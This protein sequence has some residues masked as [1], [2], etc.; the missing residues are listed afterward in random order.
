MPRFDILISG[1]TV[2]DGTGAPR[3]MADVG[4][5][6]DRIK[7]VEPHGSISAGD[8]AALRTIDARGLVVAPG[9]VDT[10]NHSDG[11]MLNGTH[12]VAK[13]TQGF[14][15][16]VLMSD[17][18]SYAPTS[19]RNARLWIA[20]LRSLDGL[21]VADYRG[22]ESIA[23]YLALIDRHNAQNCLAQIPYANIRVDAMGW[24]RGPADDT[25]IRLMQHA[26]RHAMDDGAA[27]VSTGLDYVAQCFAG[28]DEIAEVC[29]AMAL[30]G[31]LYVTHVRYK[32]GLVA[33]VKEAVEIGRRARV[34]VH[35]SHLK[36]STPEERD[37]LLEYIDRVAVHEVDF[38]FDVYPYL[39]GSTML[40]SL[41]PYDV[42]EAG[43]LAVTDRLLEPDVRR[44][45]AAQLDDYQLELDHIRLAWVA[46]KDNARYQGMSL[47][48]YSDT[49]RKS[50]VDA[51]CDLLVD[52]QLAV[53][54]VFF[55][56]DDSLV[57][58]FLT[59]PRFMIGSDGI[60]FPDTQ[61]HPRQFGSATRILGPLVRDRGL[62]TLEEAV[63][64]LS[65]FPSSRFGLTD[66][67][68]VQAGS[69]ADLVI[70]DP[71][72][73][74]DRATFENPQQTSIGIVE[75]LVNGVPVVSNGLPV[76]TWSGGPP[77]RALRFKGGFV[78]R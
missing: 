21:Q 18:I 48:E 7:A 47:A 77:G 58:P 2:I 9:F 38:T 71:Q 46:G 31:G 20:Y 70:F 30:W 62:F 49:M 35:I 54:C 44:R 55:M 61:I 4:I 56:G 12:Q 67:G 1:G 32:K 22:W 6:G 26:V 11:W 23:D 3:R 74:T 33:G 13:T 34:P 69:Y 75:V 52:E 68:T 17:G 65:G 73:V 63:R 27:G 14:T 78:R 39:P 28:T 8:A 64:K 10:H 59:H 43:P 19:Q 60:W 66:R 57:E 36:G 24:G 40:N 37:D 53:L 5:E 15:T 50:P 76:E 29:S 41:L 16:E 72:T 51:I 25:Q 42:W 45:F